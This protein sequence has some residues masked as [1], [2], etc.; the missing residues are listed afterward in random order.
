MRI[1]L[2]TIGFALVTSACLLLG[3]GSDRAGQDDGGLADGQDGAAGTDQAADAGGDRDTDGGGDPG[4]RADPNN[5]HNAELDTD[6]DGLSDQEEFATLFAGGRATDPDKPDSDGDGILDGVE[7][8]RSESVDPLCAGVFAG[9]AHPAS[10]TD[11]TSADS[12]C[13]GLA[14]GAEDL[15][16]DGALSAGETDP[17]SADTDGDGLPD[18]LERSVTEAVA[19]TDCPMFQPD[20]DPTSSTDPLRADSDGDGI[21]DGREDRDHNG[22]VDVGNPLLPDYDSGDESDP[23]LAD[24][25]G[26]G[27]SDG[28]EDRNQNLLVDPGE[29]D[30]L[31]ANLDS[32]GDGLE[33][34]AEI[35]CGYDPNDADMDDDGIP[36]GLEDANGDCTRNLGETDPRRVDTDCDGLADGIEDADHDGSVDPG[37]TRPDDPD[38]DGDG[39]ADG[40]ESGVSSNPD[41]D[42]CPDL[43]LDADPSSTTDPLAADTDGGGVNDGAEDADKDGRFDG[44]ELDPNDPLDDGGVVG[45]ACATENLAPIQFRDVSDADILLALVPDFADGPAGEIHIAPLRIDGE[46]RGL[47]FVDPVHELGGFAVDKAPEGATAS[48]EEIACRGSTP[49]SVPSGRFQTIACLDN[50]IVQPFTTW[51]G[52]GAVLATYDYA[53][54]PEDDL[55]GRLN[56]IARALL[57][58]DVEGLYAD[59]Q[60]AGADHTEPWRM[61]VE[62]VRRTD[63]RAVLVGAL[64][65]LSKISG[66]QADPVQP[67]F[68]RD[69]VNGT[70]LAQL[71]DRIGV[72]CDV[73][74]SG[75]PRIDF[76]WVVDDS[77]SMDPHQTAVALA[78]SAF[79]DKLDNSQVDYRV[80]LLSTGY[81]QEQL[82]NGTPTKNYGK[83]FGFSRDLAEFQSW[84]RQ[85]CTM[86]DPSCL[87]SAQCTGTEK[88]V[89]SV[90]DALLNPMGGAV[91]LLP[92]PGLEDPDDPQRLRREAKLVII[93]VSDA[94]DQ[95]NREGRTPSGNPAS[96][97]NDGPWWDVNLPTYLELFAQIGA[98]PDLDG[99]L[100]GAILCSGNNC[101]GETINPSLYDQLVQQTQGVQGLITS[102]AS[103]DATMQGIVDAAIGATG[104]RLS[105]PPIS[106]SLKVVQELPPAACPQPTPRH[107]LDGF[108][109][110]GVFNAVSFF[111][112]CRPEDTGRTIAVSYRYWIDA[113]PDPNG[114]PD[115]CAEPC[116]EPLEC[117][118]VTGECECPDDCGVPSPGP[119]W[120][121]DQTSCTWVCPDAC[122]GACTGYTFCHENSC[123]C[124]CTTM[125]SCP[126]GYVFDPVPCDCV[127]D[128]G[129]LGCDETHE[130]DLELCRCVCKPDC[131]GCPPNTYCRPSLCICDEIPQ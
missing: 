40:L 34:A 51:D 121:C 38:T 67:V 124:V 85:P 52:F 43:A 125:A 128:A 115:P 84:L 102:D 42:N 79:A 112:D 7:L 77:C 117:N 50:A 127:C 108:D 45:E 113:T 46:L 18:G 44:G 118:P 116:E 24:T 111:G 25:D 47:L 31:V 110:D 41:P 22:R 56:N 12:D 104:L 20:A 106:A 129:A 80:A 76:V 26:D 33:D 30:P 11:P 55:K 13:D 105:R 37:E 70:A 6:C 35:A 27:R 93:F 123:S 64:T 58:A 69:V 48:E 36:D 130:P 126:A 59:G 119:L 100:V 3:C 71:G 63:S 53:A 95:S 10:H 54:G 107:P 23:T 73:R 92:T 114:Q 109:Y 68:L 65:T 78:A 62:V 87:G 15:D 86:D 94:G 21:P 19:D 74:E 2:R 98:R 72:Q 91:P 28:A 16:L 60:E 120:V 32:D 99:L 101:G 14:D 97:E 103:V 83:V 9:D 122:G 88:G 66:A 1:C 5:P 96:D 61:Q 4:R 131:G 57:G 8:G 39:L 75:S 90:Y 89:E 17:A 81:W 82:N 29:T 49:C